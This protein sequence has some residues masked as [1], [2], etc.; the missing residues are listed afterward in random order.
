MGRRYDPLLD[1]VLMAGNPSAAHE[2]Q[3]SCM[4]RAPKPAGAQV[5]GYSDAQGRLM[6]VSDG[7]SGGQS[8]GT[9]FRKPSGALKR[10]RGLEMR[11]E[12]KEAEADLERYARLHG[13][14]PDGEQA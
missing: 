10:Y 5:H 3:Q 8:W 6:F 2:Y 7:I 13:W 14:R 12:R 4:V 1:A 11:D 9:F